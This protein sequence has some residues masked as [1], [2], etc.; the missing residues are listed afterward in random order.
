MGGNSSWSDMN[1]VRKTDYKHHN[2]DG[3]SPSK[4]NRGKG[5]AKGYGKQERGKN[6]GYNNASRNG[7]HSS[8]EN[9]LSRSVNRWLRYEMRTL[10]P[11][12]ASNWVHWRAIPGAEVD[13]TEQQLQG[14]CEGDPDH[15]ELWWENVHEGS[16]QASRSPPGMYVRSS[17]RGGTLKPFSD[18]STLEG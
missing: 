18:G 5:H 6:N 16:G 1:T 11:E 15:L 8:W 3:P 4:G 17:Y 12:N 2:K 7:R 13:F 9:R 10:Y 14:V